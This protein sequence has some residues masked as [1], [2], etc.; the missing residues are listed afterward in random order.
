MIILPFVLAFF[1]GTVLAVTGGVL[2]WDVLSPWSGWWTLAM[3]GGVVGI[4][5]MIVSAFGLRKVLN[6]L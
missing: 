3:L 4:I 6:G 1:I 2:T 5:I